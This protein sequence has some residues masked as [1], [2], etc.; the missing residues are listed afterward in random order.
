MSHFNARAPRVFA[1]VLPPDAHRPTGNQ[2][3]QKRLPDSDT[4]NISKPNVKTPPIREIQVGAV[5]EQRLNPDQVKIVVVIANQKES[6]EEVK[7]SVTRR[8]EYVLQAIKNHGVKEDKVAVSKSLTRSE[9]GEQA[10]FRFSIQITAY[11]S[12][13]QK[14][15]SLS[16]LLVEKLDPLTVRVNPPEVVPL[17]PQRLA[18]L[19]RETCLLAVHNAKQKAAEIAKHFGSFCSLGP[20]VSIKEEAVEE[21]GAEEQAIESPLSLSDLV[22][23]RARV[24]RCSVTALFE[25]RDVNA[26]NV[27]KANNNASSANVNAGGDI[28]SCHKSLSRS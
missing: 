15:E 17:H 20:P 22:S 11:F 1:T 19:R 27:N 5:G 14:C 9:E 4:E 18:D 13:F 25:L 28:G 24:V 21:W 16:N 12:D 7:S 2:Q 8:E 26:L 23:S 10:G 6:V 3:Q